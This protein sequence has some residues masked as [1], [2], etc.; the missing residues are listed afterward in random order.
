M[1]GTVTVHGSEPQNPLI[2][3]NTNET[4][5]GNIVDGMWTGLVSYGVEDGAPELAMAESIEGSADYKTWTIKIKPGWTFHDG[6]EVKAKNFVDAW[7]YGAFGPNA[8]LNQYFFSPDGLGIAGYDAVS[9]EDATVKEMSGLKVVD[10]YTFTVELSAPNSLFETIVGYTAF[11]PMPDSFFADPKAFEAKP[12][13]NGPFQFVERVPSVSVDLMAYPDYKGDRK[14]KVENVQFKMYTS[15]DAAYADVVANNLDVLDSI[16]AQA[17]AGNIWQTDLAGRFLEKPLSSVFQSISFPLYDAKFDSVDLRKAISQAIDRET[18]IDVA[19]AGT[20]VPAD[21]WVPPG[22][23]GYVAGVCGDA[24]IFD[25]AK[26]KAS[27]EAAGGFEGPLTLAYNADGGH[28]EWVDA[29]CV[30]IK[31]TLGID[32]Q[33]KPFPEFGPFREEV[34]SKAMTG[35]FRTGWQADYPSIQNF[36]A[37]LYA[38]GASANDGDY[39]NP[40]FDALIQEA[41]QVPAAEANVKY[42]EAESI[43]A[44]DMPVI[45]MWFGKFQ[46]AWSDKVNEPVFN[47]QGRVDLPSLTLK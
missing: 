42:G 33:G 31:N 2:P 35:M 19:F 30:S 9:A 26:A 15:L 4:G 12:I 5:G 13:G 23:D 32:C 47:W 45:P 10:D 16:P 14:A 6:T 18:V 43:L 1:A 29:T 8:Q 11:Y 7:N 46:G 3:T 37:P 25:P 24:C 28:K 36:L 40:A 17:L 27:L 41:V 22:N 20:R 21:G 39:S 44:T 38:T 34:T